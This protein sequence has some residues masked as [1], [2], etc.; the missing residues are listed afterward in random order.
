M[1]DEYV[2]FGTAKLLKEKGFDWECYGTYNIIE[3]VLM[4][5]HSVTVVSH[6][7]KNSTL[8]NAWIS[9]PTQQMACRWLREVHNIHIMPTIGCDVDRTPRIFY[10]IVIALFNDYGN[11]DYRTTDENEYDSPEEAIEA[12]LEYA[13]TNL[14]Q[15]G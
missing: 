15:Y 4:N 6:T 9:A 1:K 5:E 14:I 3:E 7:N 13:L 11:I 2:K 12:A 8:G 10:G